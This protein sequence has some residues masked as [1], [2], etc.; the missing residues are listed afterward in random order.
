MACTDAFPE[1]ISYDKPV[2]AAGVLVY[3]LSQS[4]YLVSGTV[5]IHACV[6]YVYRFFFTLKTFVH[7]IFCTASSSWST[8]NSPLNNTISIRLY[9]TAAALSTRERY[10]LNNASNE[11]NAFRNLTDTM[12]DLIKMVL[13]RLS[14]KRRE[15]K[16]QKS[17]GYCVEDMYLCYTK[18]KIKLFDIVDNIN[19]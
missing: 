19:K 4:Y 14:N 5:N 15:R 8:W 10:A 12:H 17:L 11:I 1:W 3:E 2:Y 16:V 9:Q 18:R 13:S 7:N 6:H